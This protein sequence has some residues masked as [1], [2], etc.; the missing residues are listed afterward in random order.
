[1]GSLLM[2]KM[3]ALSIAQRRMLVILWLTLK[4]FL[5][6]VKKGL[7]FAADF[8]ILSKLRVTQSQA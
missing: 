1:M 8:G 5:I 7:T 6:F 4:F 3:V 2:Y